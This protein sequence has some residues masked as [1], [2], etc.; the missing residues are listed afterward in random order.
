MGLPPLHLP[1]GAEWEVDGRQSRLPLRRRLRNM[2]GGSVMLKR[3]SP[4]CDAA[5][6]RARLIP[7][8]AGAILTAG[9]IG[10]C[11]APGQGGSEAAH[12]EIG[13]ASWRHRVW[14]TGR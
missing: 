11:G 7:I 13:R 14:R 8:L 12:V 6:R 10:A 9:V 1:L 5:H 2:K 3:L 4:A